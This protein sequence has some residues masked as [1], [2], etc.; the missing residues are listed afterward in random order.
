MTARLPGHEGYSWCVVGR[1]GR[2]GDRVARDGQERTEKSQ[3]KEPL[4]QF[5]ASFLF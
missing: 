1:V 3:K 2:R 5:P 4:R